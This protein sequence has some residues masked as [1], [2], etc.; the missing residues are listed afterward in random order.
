MRLLILSTHSITPGKLAQELPVE[1]LIIACDRHTEDACDCRNLEK[2]TGYSSFFVKF[3][4]T[5]EFFSFF[6]F[7]F[8]LKNKECYSTLIYNKVLSHVRTCI[9]TKDTTAE[10]V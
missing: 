3:I 9:Y 5:R 1:V 7:F 6:F 4:K 10:T 8:F 2:K